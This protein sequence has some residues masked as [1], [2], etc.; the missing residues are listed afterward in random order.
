[1]VGVDDDAVAALDH[2]RQAGK[3]D[4]A[5]V[6]FEI[7][8]Y[9]IDLRADIGQ[10]LFSREECRDEGSRRLSVSA[11]DTYGVMDGVVI[12]Y[13]NDPERTVIRH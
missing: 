3:I 8:H 1:M 12:V 10:E 6:L 5:A 7:E 11:P 4:S 9:D 2:A 13:D